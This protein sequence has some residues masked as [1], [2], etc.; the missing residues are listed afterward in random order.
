M[1]LKLIRSCNDS[2]FVTEVD[3]FLLTINTSQIINITYSF[4]NNSHVAYI[5]YHETSINIDSTEKI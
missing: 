5:T 1:K 3:T 2:Y 4:F